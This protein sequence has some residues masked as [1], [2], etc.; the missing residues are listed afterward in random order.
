MNNVI[1]FV[2][3]A[4]LFMVCNV[5]DYYTTY[6]AMRGLPPQEM[7]K[8]ELNC[9]LAPI[10]HRK[11]TVLALKLAVGIFVIT[12]CFV[13]KDGYSGIKFAAII[14]LIA[15]LNNVY[16]KWAESHCR[17]SPGRFIMEKFKLPSKDI[18]FLC[19]LGLYI[20]IAYGLS[21]L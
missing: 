16:A 3:W 11:K 2:L 12:F 20:G 9:V 15:V 6:S 19:L 1:G 5:L 17:R 18:A 8:H 7:H 4:T 13:G 10:I 21:L 14:F